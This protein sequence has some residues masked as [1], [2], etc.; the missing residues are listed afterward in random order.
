MDRRFTAGF[1]FALVVVL[2]L[3]V[4]VGPWPTVRSTRRTLERPLDRA[5]AAIEARSLRVDGAGGLAVGWASEPL[6]LSPGT[7][8]AGY[9]ERRGVA[10]TGYRDRI[11]VGAVVV[12]SGG[13]AGRDAVEGGRRARSA[14]GV[15]VAIVTAD[16]L[17]VPPA[18]AR[19][20]R[21]AAGMPVLFTAT[22]THS[23]PGAA[24]PGLIARAF[25]GRYRPA[26]KMAI[27]DAMVIAIERAAGNLQPA[28]VA[29]RSVAAG[30]LI[31]NRTRDESAT[32]YLVDPW[33]DL[34]AFEAADGSRAA[35]VRY[36]AQPPIIGPGNLELSAGYPGALRRA[37]EERE[38]GAAF[39]AGGALGSMGP[40]PPEGG[41]DFSRAARYGE[42]LAVRLTGTVPRRG[43][44]AVSTGA[45]DDAALG[46]VD[47]NIFAPPLQLRVAPGVRLSPV[48]LGLNGVTRR[49]RVTAIRL[50][51]AVLVGVPGDLSGEIAAGLREWASKRGVDLLLFSFSGA[52]LGY[53]SPDA[54][55]DE[56]Y[57]GGS[58]AYETGIMSWTGP[59]QERFFSGVVRAAVTALVD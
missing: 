49:V 40:V 46:V 7:P 56:L 54:D 14:S 55:Y 3:V 32:G 11:E 12:E 15:T 28:A 38:G 37:V 30:D 19:R 25:G 36:S 8:L 24:M 35:L 58:L 2:A 53:I 41:D 6:N 52:Y 51:N 20:V 42:A 27:V 16:L 34:V 43:E 39:F 31:R 17:V 22:H 33:L 18:I 10:A 9:G 48:L 4:I 21:E 45:G 50:G 5:V 13:G 26:V 29:L 57:D 44:A 23:G 1:A 47:L 59:A